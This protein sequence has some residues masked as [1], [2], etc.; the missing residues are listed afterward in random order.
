[1]EIIEERFEDASEQDDC[2]YS[3]VIYLIRDGDVRC[4]A[5]SHDDEPERVS[6]LMLELDR[7]RVSC[8]KLV[9]RP[10]LR[11]EA[12]RESMARI[13]EFLHARGHR[14]IEILTA[15]GYQPLELDAP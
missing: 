15:D 6:I 4:K 3:G 10:S 1:M 12:A 5:R 2:Y 9:A 8:D 14:R 13:V 7:S 11:N